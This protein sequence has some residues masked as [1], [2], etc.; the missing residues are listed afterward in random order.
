MNVDEQYWPIIQERI[1]SRCID[2]GPGAECRI[3]GKQECSIRRF[4]PQ[5]VEIIRSVESTSIVPYET[6]LRNRI[7]SVCTHQSADGVCLVRNEV[8][9]ALDRY[10]PLIVEV[11]EEV[12]QRGRP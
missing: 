8:E 6:L 10:F 11:I 7:C 9:C 12:Q 5:I 2:A 3:G 1:C 4:F